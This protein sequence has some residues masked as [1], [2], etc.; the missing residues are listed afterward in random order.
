MLPS[1]QPSASIKSES[2]MTSNQIAFGTIFFHFQNLVPK[3]THAE[4]IN[5]G[6]SLPSK[7]PLLLSA[8]ASSS[9]AVQALRPCLFNFQQLNMIIRLIQS[10]SHSWTGSTQS[11]TPEKASTPL[12]LRSW[13]LERRALIR[14]PRHPF[15]CSKC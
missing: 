2:S 14:Q 15:P 10:S 4:W 7:T 11:S 1:S 6:S 9:S 8:L 13:D 12:P 5:C 3:G